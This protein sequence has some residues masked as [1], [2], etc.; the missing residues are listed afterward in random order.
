[1]LTGKSIT[2]T[3]ENFDRLMT[4][5]AD[6]CQ[7]LQIYEAK[8][9]KKSQKKLKSI[10]CAQ[11][12]AE[13]RT[14]VDHLYRKLH[15]AST[16]LDQN[17]RRSKNALYFGKQAISSLFYFT[18]CKGRL[19]SCNDSDPNTKTPL[20]DWLRFILYFVDHRFGMHVDQQD[21]LQAARILLPNVDCPPYTVDLVVLSPSVP[22]NIVDAKKRRQDIAFTLLLTAENEFVN[23]AYQ[24]LGPQKQKAMNDYVNIFN[25]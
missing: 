4:P 19:C 23:E 15:S 16:L 9:L 3:E 5:H 22:G 17:S 13:L 6:V 20:Y 12:E 18:R 1:M 24:L 25:Y 2:V 8:R 7:F 21:V 14:I 10:V 11:S